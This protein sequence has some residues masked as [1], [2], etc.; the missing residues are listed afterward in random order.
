[1]N[2]ALLQRFIC[3]LVRCNSLSKATSLPSSSSKILQYLNILFSLQPSFS[4]P[5]MSMMFIK[6]LKMG[7]EEKEK[8]NETWRSNKDA[9][10]YDFFPYRTKFFASGKFVLQL[11]FDVGKVNFEQLR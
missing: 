3:N 1:M 8:N 6:T 9:S 7:L 5:A 2:E 10:R 11:Q 4:Q